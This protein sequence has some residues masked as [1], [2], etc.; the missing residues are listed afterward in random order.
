MTTI[1]AA[2][3][4]GA[5]CT[6]LLKN[7]TEFRI[8]DYWD[9]VYGKSWGVSDGNWAAMA[10]AVRAGIEGLPWDDEVVY[11]KDPAG[12][13]HLIHVNELGERK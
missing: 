8:E 3:F 6:Y 1:H 12:L 9:R 13:G 11:G 10:Y 4:D 7:G 2:P 5:G